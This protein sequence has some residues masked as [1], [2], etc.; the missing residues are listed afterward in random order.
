MTDIQ[1]MYTELRGTGLGHYAALNAM[2]DR[3]GLDKA[4]VART[5]GKAND[6][7]K[8]HGAG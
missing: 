2:A 6:F 7:D 3:L 5:L 8:K 4:S 1:Q